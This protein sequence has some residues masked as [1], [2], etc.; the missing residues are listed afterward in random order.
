MQDYLHLLADEQKANEIKQLREQR[1]SWK[2]DP[3]LSLFAEA[4]KALPECEPSKKIY[5][6]SIVTIGD[7]ADISG[8]QTIRLQESLKTFIPWKKGPFSF[9]GIDIDAEWRSDLK[10][11]R[12]MGHRSSLRGK[13]VADIGCHNGYFMYRMLPE[14]PRLVVGFEPY[15]KHYYAFHLAQKY[16][17]E[18]NLHF[19]LLGIEHFDLY[20]N[21]FDTI[22][23]L[24]ILYHHPDPIGLLKKMR[25]AL[26]PG[27][28]IIIDCQGI[29]GETATALMPKSRY[30]KAKGIWWL[31][32]KTCLEHWM[33]RSMYRDV[34]CFYSEP[35]GIDEQRSTTWAPIDSLEQFLDPNDPS[36]TIEGY[37]APWRFYLRAKK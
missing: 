20:P 31:P 26:K 28:E 25:D 37:P 21:F 4:I 11:Q 5:S 24:G 2:V 35:L 29:P 13:I 12:I 1:E 27:G 16:A 14:E 15:A 34:D 8:D 23:C 10:W 6:G 19:E 17:K 36:K 18:E 33:S 7:S 3:K 32:T 30:A 22:F 9:F